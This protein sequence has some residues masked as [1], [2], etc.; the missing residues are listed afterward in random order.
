M[1]I[2]FCAKPEQAALVKAAGFDTIELPVNYIAAMDDAAFD[3]C[4][5]TLKATELPCP[6]FNL[7]FPGT[8]KL[9]EDSTTDEEIRTYLELALSRVECLGGQIV[10][11]GSGRSR[12]RPDGMP[13]GKAFRRLVDVTK[14]AGDTAKRHGIT[15]V[16]EP[17]NRKECNMIN[18]MAEGAALVSA[19]DHENVSLL[20]DY[21]H[22]TLDHEPVSDI[23]RLTG[24]CHVHIATT[25]GRLVP[26]V[27]D[28][29]Y[30]TLVKALKATGYSG[31]IS[32]E[33]KSDD[34]MKDGPV[35]VKMLK[36]LWNEIR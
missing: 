35:S 25:K 15:I 24:V 11:F 1:K 14:M 32:V 33:G 16:I 23:E 22:V 12:N 5:N 10:V 19:T 3:T 34:L 26:T 30:E 9:L 2:G 21:Y 13:Y 28:E 4:R 31:M 27:Y 6:T 29:G 7:L 36:D 8:L 20:S 18:S 17:L